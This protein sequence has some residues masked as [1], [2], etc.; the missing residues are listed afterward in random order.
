MPGRGKSVTNLIK[1][2]TIVNYDTSVIIYNH[3]AFIRYF[4]LL[5]LGVQKYKDIGIFFNP[6]LLPWWSFTWVTN[7]H[8]PILQ[9]KACRS[10][11]NRIKK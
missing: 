5:Y 11:T 4:H 10:P 1:H 2:S 9:L 8:G 3:R 6:P 7:A